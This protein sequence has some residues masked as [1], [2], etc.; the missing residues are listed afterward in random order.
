MEFRV[1][2][3]AMGRVLK[4]EQVGGS[5]ILAAILGILF[6][7]FLLMLFAGAIMIGAYY[8]WG[9]I[10]GLFLV[11]TITLCILSHRGS[12]G[13]FG[14]SVL[15]AFLA[16]PYM[17]IAPLFFLA[18]F[19]FL[20]D[21]TSVGDFLLAQGSQSRFWPS[22]LYFGLS[23]VFAIGISFLLVRFFGEWSN[24]G[25]KE[26]KQKTK[27]VQARKSGFARLKEAEKKLE[28]RKKSR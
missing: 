13:K 14:S 23:P 22:Y 21:Q 10:T 3:D 6:A 28:N 4:I 27:Q 11:F 17:I 15:A 8:H 2:T 7:P 1:I 16:F 9:T 5:T 24:G 12:Q 20:A 19:G 26:K 18:P 25:Q